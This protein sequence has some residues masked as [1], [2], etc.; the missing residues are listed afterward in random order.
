MTFNFVKAKGWQWWVIR[1]LAGALGLILL[2]AG[3]LKGTN[4]ELFIRQIRYYGIIS[5]YLVL[6][7]SAW[8]LIVVECTLGTALLVFYRPRIT[9]PMTTI[10][11]L[12]FVGLNS[13]AWMNKTTGDCGCFG[14]WLKRTPGQGALEG[15]IMLASLVPARVWKKRFQG[16]ATRAKAVAVVIACL[17]GLVLPLASG[18]PVSKI[19]QFQWRTDKMELGRLE[20][21]GI[22]NVDLSRGDYLVILMDTD[23]QHCREA[24]PELNGLAEVKGIPNLIA[25][26]PNGD[27][28]RKK[29]IEA[30]QP[31]FPV[32]QIREDD[33]WRLLGEGNVPRIMLL[34]DRRVQRIWD[35]KVP[36]EAEIKKVGKHE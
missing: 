5:Q 11:L 21:N 4:I 26:T 13:W 19:K 15:L 20:I 6:T 29:F 25:L 12:I 36:D 9:V 14:A 27:T 35:G 3:L 23:C 33:F 2:T 7:G 16:S 31:A 24:I 17:V 28:Q 34:H 18:F 10:L 8:G 32:V 22:K 1:L 30:F